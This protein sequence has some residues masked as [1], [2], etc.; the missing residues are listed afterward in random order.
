MSDN[1]ERKIIFPGVAL[2]QAM[3]NP[4]VRRW[5]CVV[6][7]LKASFATGKVK[8][9]VMTIPHYFFCAKDGEG[10]WVCSNKIFP[11]PKVVD[12]VDA[13]LNLCKQLDITPTVDPQ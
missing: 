4:V 3:D 2:S 6:P 12:P 10:R 11:F 13:Y 5:L 7:E 8:G 1:Q 9:I